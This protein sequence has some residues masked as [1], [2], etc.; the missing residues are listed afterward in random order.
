M[1]M[2]LALHLKLLF[3]IVTC[4]TKDL[5]HFGLEPNHSTYSLHLTFHLYDLDCLKT[6]HTFIYVIDISLDV[7]VIV[8][9]PSFMKYIDE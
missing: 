6:H 3:V 9:R 7:L 4:S 2:Q 5:Y 8:L 1:F